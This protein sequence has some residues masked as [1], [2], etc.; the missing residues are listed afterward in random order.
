M[1]IIAAP[2]AFKGSLAAPAAAAAIA[3]G[4]K[5][6]DPACEVDQVP[7][8]DG[9]DGTAGCFVA[10]AG[11]RLESHTVCGPLGQPV[12]AE[13][14]LLADGRTAVVEMAAASGLALV[15]EARRDPWLT[16]S[17]GTGELIAAATRRGRRR[18]IVGIGGSATVDGGMGML[19]ALGVRFL[20]RNGE[21]VPEGGQGLARIAR[22]DCSDLLPELAAS[23]LIVASDVTNPLCGPNGAAFVF[24]PQKGATAE[25]VAALDAGLGNLARAAADLGLAIADFPGAG[26][27][28]GAGAA[29]GGILGARMVP[30]AQLLMEQCGFAERLRHADL[31]FTGEG[32]IDATTAAGKVPAAV[33]QAAAA[34]GV[35]VIVLGGEIAAGAEAL[36]GIGRVAL[37]PIVGG[38]LPLTAAMSCAAELIERASERS[39]RLFTLGR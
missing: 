10:A 1:R 6:F 14:G 12:Q 39:L 19:S 16:T 5:R 9:G 28:G 18:I 21:P 32:R 20:D 25:Q 38:P 15:P 33:C 24:G 27:A 7:L 30:G 8:A 2:N 23:E 22:I 11:G 13:L 34:A 4:C 26:A 3:R 17:R 37:M 36:C 29:L 31:V 35:P